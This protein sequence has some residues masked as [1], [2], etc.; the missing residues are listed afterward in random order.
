MNFP[1]IDFSNYHNA[2]LRE[3]IQNSILKFCL[4]LENASY[5]ISIVKGKLLTY[6]NIKMRM[7]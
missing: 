4:M 5:F 6:P 2:P 3:M 7:T 1:D